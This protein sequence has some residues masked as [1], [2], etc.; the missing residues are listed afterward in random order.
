MEMTLQNSLQNDAINEVR[1]GFLKY[2][3]QQLHNS[4]IQ[5]V[6]R[7]DETASKNMIYT[8]ADKFN[9]L[10]SQNNNLGVLKTELNLD[11]M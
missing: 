1:D 9:F 4:K 5:V 6:T 7:V 2:I 8:D 10:N 11:F 3:R